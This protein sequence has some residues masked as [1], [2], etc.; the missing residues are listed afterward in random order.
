MFNWFKKSQPIVEAKS[1]SFSSIAQGSFLDYA[2]FGGGRI[3]ASN[4]AEFYRKSSAVAISVDTIAKE[5][6]QIEPVVLLADG[7]LNDA[8]PVLELLKKP[9]EF[10]DYRELMGQLARNFLL[11][12]DAFIYAEGGVT[13]PP[14]NIFCPKN[15]NVTITQN[16]N[17][18][19][20]GQYQIGFGFGTGNY[21][22]N[23]EGKDLTFIDG[24]LKEL[25]QIHGY[26]SRSNNINADS[27]LEAAALETRQQISGRNHNLKLIENGG[28][29]SLAVIFKTEMDPT[30]WNERKKAVL[31]QFVGSENAGK[32]AVF[33][34]PDMELEELGQSNKDMDFASLDKM[35]SN[36]IFLRYNIP[37]PIIS[38]Q[39]QTFNNFDRAIEDLYDRAVIPYTEIIFSGLTRMLKARYKDSFEA[40][41]FNPE[42]IDAL[43]GRM[44]EELKLRKEINIETPNELRKGLP[45][46]EDINGGDVLYQS[47]LL[48]PIGEDIGTGEPRVIDDESDT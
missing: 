3:T 48:T 26:S 41:T 17:D 33:G 2:L 20:P 38:Q 34:A 21:P 22:R 23:K 39:S 5:M 14:I 37:L 43:K 19:Y 36:S 46:R 1:F 32:V 6:E 27:P 29:L 10:E 24:G 35:S 28:R 9:N 18:G 4:A 30:Q 13:R 42:N 47:S 31:E 11:N 44:L 8:H 15:Q 16:G 40:I 45:N 12:H 7:S 25:Y